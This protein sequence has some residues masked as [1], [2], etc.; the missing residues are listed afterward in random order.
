MSGRYI[1][2]AVACAVIV[3][4]CGGGGPRQDAN[5]PSGDFKVQV[6]EAKFPDHQSLAKRSR[7]TI[8]VKNVDSRTIPNVAVTVDS[9]DQTKNDPTLADPRRPR[10]IVNKGPAGGDTAYVGTSA[11][12]PLEPGRTKTFKWDVTAVVAGKYSLKYAIAAGLNGKAKAVLAGGGLPKGKFTGTIS[13]RAPQ[14]KVADDGKTV[15]TSGG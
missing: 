11:L 10:F 15:V 7:M 12:G 9:F 4:G 6:I 3:A 14:A 2:A 8:T 1:G 5:E 13:G